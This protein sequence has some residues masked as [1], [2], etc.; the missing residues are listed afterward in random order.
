MGV[1]LVGAGAS[2]S[3]ADLLAYDPFLIGA[4]PAAGEYTVGYLDPTAAAGGG[5][6]PTIGIPPTPSFFSGGW[7]RRTNGNAP[8]GAVQ[9]V[10][11]NY[12]GTDELG[13]SAY[14]DRVNPGPEGSTDADARIGRSLLNP[15]T[16]STVGTFYVSW[17][18]NFGALQPGVTAMGY[19]GLEFYQETTLPETGDQDYSVEYN[20]YFS[21]L[22]DIQRNPSTGRLALR[23]PGSSAILDNSPLSFNQDGATHLV[24]FKFDLTANAA[25]DTISVYLDPVTTNEP[26]PASATIPDLDITVGTFAFAMYGSGGSI[27]LAVDELRVATT[28]AEA[29]PPGLPCPGDTDGNCVIDQVD[30]DTIMANFHRTGVAGGPSEGDVALQN[31]NIG[32]DGRVSLGDLWLWKREY[33][34]ANGAGSA[35][36]F[37]VPEPSSIGLALIL[38]AMMTT[39]TRRRSSC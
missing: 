36:R 11:M 13:G 18:A 22:G 6:N 26:E 29:L 25:G 20:E 37:F 38:L 30:F 1:A 31:G 2:T 14:V 34:A 32:I 12:F 5:Q 27:G 10:P 4:S 17:V 23:T 15:W 7:H 9:N 19:R 21:H 3:Y 28:F 35:A 16:A 39:K 33:E 24:V 8:R